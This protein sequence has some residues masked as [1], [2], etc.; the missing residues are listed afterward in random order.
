MTDGRNRGTVAVV[1]GGRLGL[2]AAHAALAA[3]SPV[4]VLV[5]DRQRDGSACAS[6]RAAVSDSLQREVRRGALSADEAAVLFARLHV[7]TEPRDLASAEVVIEAVPEDLATKRAVIEAIESSVSAGCLIASSTSSL[8][9]ASL[10]ARARHPERVVVA[11]YVWPAHR[12]PLVEVALHDATSAAAR[13]RL[14]LLL[15]DQGKTVVQV[16]DRPGFLITRALLAYWNEAVQL[17]VEGVDPAAVDLALE[18]F[19]M[20]LG[21]LRMMDAAG[22]ATAY[23]V[24]RQVSASGG[25]RHL[26]LGRLGEVLDCGLSGFYDHRHRVRTP[27]RATTAALRGPDADAHRT[28]GDPEHHAIIDRVIG[29]LGGEVALA[30]ADGVVASWSEAGLAIDLAYG[31]PASRGGLHRWWSGDR[32]VSASEAS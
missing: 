13:T 30:V 15:A 22:I 1:G 28:A 31:F 32:L 11:H 29:A 5:R 12:I 19:G 18:T 27:L 21:P 10:A 7:T 17:V 2:T 8:P 4:M 25:P 24:H 23:A 3:G 26:A 6:R 9:A 16:V 14:R 20:P